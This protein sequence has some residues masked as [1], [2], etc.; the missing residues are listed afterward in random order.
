MSTESALPSRYEVEESGNAT[1]GYV[2]IIKCHGKVISQ[3]AG[4]L[5]E[6][7]KPLIARGGRIVLDFTDVPGVDSAGL[8]VLVGLKVSAIGA[9]Y[10]TLEFT[11]LSQRVQDLL[12]LTKLS[13]LFSQAG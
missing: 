2:T 6:L 8:G 7:V 13:Q 3:T 12:H 10:C 5:K 1:T 9:G 11:N 4:E